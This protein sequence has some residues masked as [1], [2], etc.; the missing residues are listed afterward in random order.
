LDNPCI[1]SLI[2]ATSDINGKLEVNIIPT[3]PNGD[4]D[5]PDELIPDEPMDLVGQ[6]IDFNVQIIRAYDLPSYFCKDVYCEYQFYIDKEKYKT[7]INEGKN[8]RPEFEF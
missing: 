7:Q 3:D 1:I 5:L 2:G 8:Q 6:R 4:P